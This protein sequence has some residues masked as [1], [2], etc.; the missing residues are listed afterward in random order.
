MIQGFG[1]NILSYIPVRAFTVSAKG[2]FHD[3]EKEV[4]KHDTSTWPTFKNF[5]KPIAVFGILRG[6]ANLIKQCMIMPQV[7]YYFDHAYMFGNR[8]QTSKIFNETIYRVTRNDYSLTYIDK[9]DNE[10]YERI[11]KYKPHYEIKEWKKEGKYI[12]VI[13]PSDYAKKYFGRQSWLEDT[14]EELKQHT[15][16]D[17]L[18]RKKDVPNKQTLEQQ[19][20]E[21]FACVTFQ[22]TACI[23][24]ILN[25]VPNFCDGTSC[26]LPVSNIQLSQIENPTY[27]DKRKEWIESLLANQFT[28]TEFE[29][30]TAYKKVSRWSFK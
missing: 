6:T 1:T 10:D 9:L 11:E 15:K 21:A 2:F 18:V 27:S 3:A 8:H 4:Y 23:E 16:R 22:S 5:D 17:I 26:G 30:D 24:A 25:G 19:L 12:L 20:Q 14:I 29:N 28:K 13:D 7:F